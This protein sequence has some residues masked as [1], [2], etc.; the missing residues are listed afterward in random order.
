M[1]VFRCPFLS[2]G[3]ISRYLMIIYRRPFFCVFCYLREAGFLPCTYLRPVKN[4]SFL[5]YMSTKCL[6]IRL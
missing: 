6:A 3:A 1:S 4:G 5:K 2:F